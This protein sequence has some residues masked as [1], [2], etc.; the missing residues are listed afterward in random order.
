[1]GVIYL[2]TSPSGK[3]YV[4]QHKTN[5]FETRKKSHYQNYIQFL[6][7][8]IVLALKRQFN[9]GEQYPKNPKGFCT[10]FYNACQKYGFHRF[11]WALLHSDISGDK[12]NDLENKEMY[13]HKTIVPNGYN[14]K[15]NGVFD[16]VAYSQQTIDQMTSSQTKVWKTH[17]HKY[18]RNTEE[19][20]GLPMYVTYYIRNGNPCYR[21]ANHPKCKSKSFGSSKFTPDEL[22]QQ[23][24]NH[25]AHI[26]ALDIEPIVYKRPR[27]TNRN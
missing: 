23:V 16:G 17:L 18:R 22:K 14:L 19:L 5:D 6:K 24:L 21:I 1:M 12:L 27:G 8:K 20:D 7:R 9:P 10:A 3:Q 26:D 4:G 15:Y 13:E 2:V 25:L 11:T